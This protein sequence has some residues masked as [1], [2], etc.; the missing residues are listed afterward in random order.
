M[1]NILAQDLGYAGQIHSTG[2]AEVIAAAGAVS[3]DCDESIIDSAG[4]IA[5]TLAAPINNK[6][7]RKKIYMRTDGGNATL[8][9]ALGLGWTTI[10]F[11]DVG[12]SCELYF[13]GAK[14]VFLGGLGVTP[15]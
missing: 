10:V 15:S 2:E 1:E 3:P 7:V 6:K 8:T 12:D 5:L 11:G 14:W 9:V 4:A 13:N